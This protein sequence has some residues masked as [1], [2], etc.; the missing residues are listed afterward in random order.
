MVQDSRLTRENDSISISSK[1]FW[2]LRHF[3]VFVYSERIFCKKFCR[4]FWHLTPSSINKPNIELSN[5]SWTEWR[6]LILLQKQGKRDILNILHSRISL[7]VC[8]FVKMHFYTN[9]RYRKRTYYQMT[10][11]WQIG[12]R[13]LH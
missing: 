2:F 6:H 7:P 8:A 1:S 5:R 10:F 4:F 12:F 11:S 9:P 13:W 3:L